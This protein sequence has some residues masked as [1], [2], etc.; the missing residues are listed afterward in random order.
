MF[1]GF[2]RLV[3]S[4]VKCFHNSPDDQLYTMS[5]HNEKQKHG[6]TVCYFLLVLLHCTVLSTLHLHF[7]ATSYSIVV[8]IS[9]L[10]VFWNFDSAFSIL[11]FCLMTSEKFDST[12]SLLPYFSLKL[13]ILHIW[14]YIFRPLFVLVFHFCHTYGSRCMAMALQVHCAETIER[15]LTLLSLRRVLWSRQRTVH[16]WPHPSIYQTHIWTIGHQ[17]LPCVISAA[18]TDVAG[19]NI[20]GASPSTA[21][22]G[23]F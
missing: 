5:C 21:R 11:R 15:R 22:H 8:Y 7:T 3:F 12:L 1:R 23:R 17:H 13:L 18:A 14:L 4:S 20:G 19:I 2:N 16:L 10:R 9:N 6:G